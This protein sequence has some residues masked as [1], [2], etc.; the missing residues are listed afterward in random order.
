MTGNHLGLMIHWKGTNG[1]ME[2][3]FIL[4]QEALAAKDMAPLLQLGKISS[5]WWTTLNGAPRT[6]GS[7]KSYA[8]TRAVSIYRCCI[9]QNFSGFGGERYPTCLAMMCGLHKLLICVWTVKHIKSVCAREGTQ[10]IWTV[11]K[12][13]RRSKRLHCGQTLFPKI[14]LTCFPMLV[15]RHNDWTPQAK[16]LW[17]KK[18]QHISLNCK[19]GLTTTSQKNTEMTT[20]CAIPTIL[21]ASR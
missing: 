11:F 21:K 14:G 19:I 10:Y 16:M 15:M 18:A 12:K 5:K 2:P 9:M 20:G 7:F 8:K 4:H 1:D 13:S 3:L 17:R 6:T